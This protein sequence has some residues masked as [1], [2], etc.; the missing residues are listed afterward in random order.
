MPNTPEIN[1]QRRRKGEKPTGQAVA[2][3][4]REPGGGQGSGSGSGLGGSSGGGMGGSPFGGGGGGG[5]LFTPTR[6]KVGGCGGLLGII[7]IV[8]IYMLLSQGGGLG[9]DQGQVPIDQPPVT[10]QEPTQIRATQTPRATRVPSTSGS[11]DTWLVMLYQDADDQA[12]EQD[13]YLDLN[14]AEKV[15]STDKVTIVAQ[16]DRFRGGFQGGEDWTSTRR[17][18][19]TQDDDLNNIGSEL[20]DDL[21]ETNMADGQTLVDFVSWA[22]ETYPADRYALVL[23]DHGM[24]WPG[25]WSDPTGGADRGSAPLISALQGDSIYLSELEGALGQIQA[26]TGIEKLDLIGMDACLMS[27]MEVYAMLQP[28]ARFAVASEETEPGLGWAYAAFLNDLVNNPAMDGAQLATDIVDTYIGQDQRIVDNQARA[29]FLRQGSSAGGFF[30]APS[31]SAAQISSQIERDITLTALD[32]DAFA[33]LNSAFNDFAYALQSVDQRAIAS[34]RNYTQSYTSIF[35]R[36]VPPS[37][38]DLGHFVQLAVK[39][40]GDAGLQSAAQNVMTALNNALVAE[41]HGTSKPG[42]TGVAIYFPNSTLYRSPYTGMQS[43]TM[44]ADQFARVSLWDDFLV[45]HYN[46]RS[47]QADAAEPVVPSSS[48]ITRAPGA[49]NIAIT[50]VSGENASVTPGDSV[51]LSVEISGENVGYVYLFAGL[52]DQ[53][54]DSI[55]VADTDYLESSDTQNL[56]GVFYPVWPEGGTFRMNFDWEPILFQITDGSQAAL[57][58]FNPVSYGASAADAAYMVQGRYTF[59]DSGE[60]RQAQLIFKDSK[61]Y[62]VFGFTGTD[63]AGAPREITPSEGDTFTIANK[64]L[65]NGGKDVIYEDGDTLTFGAAPFTWEQIYAPAGEYVVGFLVSD[66]DGNVF[67]ANTQVTVR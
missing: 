3:Q 4:R 6:G 44:L 27:Q 40:T 56:N 21:G 15:G 67:D 32:L 23:S 31:I 7:A 63:T 9:G 25:G 2:P 48:N 26:N 29:D 8:V 33:G 22:V 61:L 51:Q 28:Y 54:S 19:V 55:Y 53:S 20:V 50:W 18:L 13:I 1:V 62:Q 42:S 45:Y 14:E 16:M 11:G 12:L 58:L 57:A 60:E 37:Y 49:G 35:G 39:Q 30:G 17:Y 64:W 36:E 41:R 59:A 46:D 52:Y 43:Y 65:T 47:F 66:L 5:G 38:I 34:A 10:N 24:G